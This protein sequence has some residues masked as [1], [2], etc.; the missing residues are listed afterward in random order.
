MTALLIVLAAVCLFSV[1]TCAQP[2]LVEDPRA[3]CADEGADAE[4]SQVVVGWEDWGGDPR[5]LRARAPGDVV[6]SA[7]T[8]DDLE[9]RWAFAI[10]GATDMRSQPAVAGRRLFLAGRDGA[11]R[12]LDARLGC[13]LWETKGEVPLRSGVALG[14]GR[15]GR[16]ALFVGD[17]EGVVHALD[18]ATGE[19]LWSVSVSDHPHAWITGTPAAHGGRLYVP[20][21]S[22]EVGMAQD[23]A[24]ECCTFRGGV[25]AL[26]AASGEIVWEYRAV[27]ESPVA[28]APSSDGTAQ[29][30][31]SGAAVWSTPTIDTVRKRL[32]F[33]VGQNYSLPWTE[34]SSAIHAID[35]ET[36]ERRWVFQA[37]Q[38]DAWNMACSPVKTLPDLPANHTANC[39]AESGRDFDFGAPPMLVELEDGR[40]LLVAGQKS[41]VVYALDPDEE[42]A[43]VWETRVGR[44]GLLGGIHWGL[45]AQDELVFVPVSDRFDG[46]SYDHAP[47]AGLVAL[48]AATGEVA[49]SASAPADSCS[50]KPRGCDGGFSAPV[51]V[52]PGAVLAGSLAGVLTAFSVEGGRPLWS[53]DTVRE[54]TTVDGSLGSGGSVDVAGPIVAGDMMF[55]VSG[56]SGFGQMPGNVLLAFSTK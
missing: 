24:Y 41:G 17:D 20:V 4:G 52:V 48:R 32:Y 53:F 15:D 3:Q 9:L 36:G 7:E 16:Q 54:F 45:A 47:A 42:G 30:G 1:L 39:P 18:S 35:L 51:T 2:G 6:L 5:N 56:Y 19:R 28:R 49:W 46:V 31:P 43:V 8:V 33:G 23:P 22:T 26:D 55:A 27:R 11:V 21:S 50:G 10:D 37:T 38:A 13:V 25:I 40:E 29:W 34:E 12:A 44:G 14:E